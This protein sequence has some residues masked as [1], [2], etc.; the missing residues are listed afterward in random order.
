M[1]L[2]CRKT[3]CWQG[4]SRCSY[5]SSKYKKWRRVVVAASTHTSKHQLKLDDWHKVSSLKLSDRRKLLT[6]S[7]IRA[8]TSVTALHQNRRKYDACCKPAQLY[9]QNPILSNPIGSW[10]VCCQ[11]G[12]CVYTFLSRRKLKLY[13]SHFQWSLTSKW[14]AAFC[15][16]WQI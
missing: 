8:V 1:S 7:F 10:P 16:S 11:I 14:E 12:Y 5:A 6:T 3:R 9:S 13:M 15:L 2:W 4:R